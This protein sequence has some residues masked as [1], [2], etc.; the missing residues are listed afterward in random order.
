MT[1]KKGL[2]FKTVCFA[3]EG[4]NSF[5]SV[6][7]FTYLY[8]LMRARFGFDDKN[9]L[10]LAAAIG[11]IYIYTSWQ[12]GRF[13]QRRGY[14]TALKLGFTVMIL[15]LATGSQLNSASGQILAAFGVAVGMCFTWATLEALVSE[16]EAPKNLPRV[17]GIYN[18]V[19]A[20]T[21]ALA[22]FFG[23]TF[24]E[25]FGFKSIFF[26]PIA[27]QLVQ[28]ALTF[29]L[30]KHADEI[31]RASANRPMAAPPPDP[32]RPSP[33]KAKAFLRMA[34]L[35]NPFA[36]IAIN[37]LIAV[38]SGIAAKFHLSPMF[39]GFGGSL[40]CFARLGAFFAL[41]FW[42]GWHY[43]FR[44]LVTAFALLI[45]SFTA[46]LTAPNLTVLIVAQLFFGWAIGLIY[47][48]SLFYSMDA[49]EAKGDHG[50]IHEAA[51]G[52]GNCIGPAVGA[53][54]LQFFPQ[55]SHNGV[56]AVSGL[57]SLG[58]AALVAVQWHARSRR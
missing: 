42:T 36:Y 38:L 56:I 20:S 6:T 9:N 47:Y 48:S 55:H 21:A 24:I 8:F 58:L 22:F 54:S 43:R 45:V 37:T 27:I 29:W 19:W 51:V 57:L 12:A 14:F 16:G 44:W 34:W 26:I 23:G 49:G 41:W 17:I 40:W 11:F 5:A 52:M 4:L 32:N 25:A 15:S 31:A 10:T 50:G 33:A 28:L 3:I 13:A 7:Y 30:Q 39:A 53:A 1:M 2:P 46:I 18:I 35:A